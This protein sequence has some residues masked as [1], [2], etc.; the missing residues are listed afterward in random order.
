MLIILMSYGKRGG[1][2]ADALR[3]IYGANVPPA[4]IA[5]RDIGRYLCEYNIAKSREDSKA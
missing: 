2:D 4:D 5:E 3:Q 1:G